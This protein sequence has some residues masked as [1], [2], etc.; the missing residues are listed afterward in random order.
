[1]LGFDPD[2]RRDP[3]PPK[4]NKKKMKRFYKE[5]SVTAQ[6]GGYAVLL[7]GKP[8]RTPGGNALELPTEKLASAIAAEWRGQ[9]DEIVPPPC[10]C[11]AWPIR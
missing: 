5:V 1:M 11:C 8:V 7:D 6:D 9:G 4:K 10:R 2:D 3:F